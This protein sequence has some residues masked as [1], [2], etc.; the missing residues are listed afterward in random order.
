MKIAFVGASGYGSKINIQEITATYE[1]KWMK[2]L[3]SRFEYIKGE[4][5]T[6][7][8]NDRCSFSFVSIE[9]FE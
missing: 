5:L 3:L 9:Y 4:Q 2:G 1:Y 6:P 8:K 7:T